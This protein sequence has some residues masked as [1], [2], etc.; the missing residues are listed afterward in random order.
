MTDEEKDILRK[1]YEFISKSQNETIE[2]QSDMNDEDNK[3]LPYRPCDNNEFPVGIYIFNKTGKPITHFLT[4]NSD[5]IKWDANELLKFV[6]ENDF[7][8]VHSKEYV[9]PNGK[10]TAN[11]YFIK[12]GDGNTVC[13]IGFYGVNLNPSDKKKGNGTGVALYSNLPELDFK[14]I[15]DKIKSLSKKVTYKSN[16]ISLVIQT[17]NGYETQPFQLP[18]QKLELEMNYGSGFIPVHQKIISRLNEQKGKGLVLLHGEP[19][20]GKTHYL[21][22]L[23]SKIKNKKVMFIPPYLA[24]FITSPEMTPFLIQNANSVLFIEDA[25]KVITDRTTNGSNGV[26]NILNLTDGILSDILNIQVV[27]TFNMDKKQIDS[28]L[29]RKGR[30]IAE[31]KFGKL[32]V[33]E[34]NKLI[35]HL[36]IG[37]YVTKIPMTLTEIY[38]IGEKEFKSEERT[39]IGFNN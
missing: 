24:D 32:N 31:H 29:L 18:K 3:I 10:H 21:K 6:G 34:S 23:A 36:K 8:N 28:A 19:G 38:N 7:K 14:T 27:A 20:T 22:Y 30:L 26:S 5:R 13:A 33:E 9:D 35:N 39:K 11:Q 15:V 12:E 25:E 16:K 4:N 1:Q 37:E 2:T 17:R